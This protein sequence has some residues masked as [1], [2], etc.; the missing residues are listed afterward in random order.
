[1]RASLK[2]LLLG[3]RNLAVLLTPARAETKLTIMVFQGLQNLPLF[4]AQTQGFFAKRGLASGHQDCADLG[5]DC[6]TASPKGAIRSC[7]ARSTMR[8]RWRKSPRPTS[9]SCAAATTAGWS[10]SCS[11]TSVRSTDLRG[12]TVIVDAPNTAYALQLYDILARSGLKK[13]DYEVKVGRG[14]VPPGPSDPRRQ[15][16][17]P[18]RCST[19]RS[20]SR[21][22]GRAE[23]PWLGGEDHWPVSGERRL[24]DARMGAAERRH[25]G[26]VSAGLR[27]RRALVAQSGEQGR[28]GAAADGQP[29]ARRRTWRRSPIRSRPMR[30]RASTRTRR[31]TSKVS[32]TCSSCA[33]RISARGAATRPIPPSTST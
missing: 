8:S 28:G 1:M 23:E 29:Q 27:G 26:E 18:P 4:A 25:A 22:E 14:D 3:A 15:D 17:L 6:A 32:A 13:G 21:R 5:R 7:T 11:P 12:K 33:Q 24:R 30:R 31:S 19:R 2:A 9:R 16:D 10:S 20:R